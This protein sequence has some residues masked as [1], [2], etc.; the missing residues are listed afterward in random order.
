MKILVVNCGSSS[1]KCQLIEIEQE[2]CLA[3][4]S[5][6][7][8]GNNAKYS[9]EK[10]D[11]NKVK[12]ELK[13]I[14][15]EIAL[16]KIIDDLIQNNVINSIN[17]VDAIGH[18]IVHGGEFFKNSVIINDTV[19]LGIQNCCDLAPLHNPAHL[20]GINAC[21]KIFDK[22]M[23]A[24]FDT[25]FHQTM[26]KKAFIYP[27][28]YEYYEKYH[29]RKYGFHGTSH[30]Y[31]SKKAAEL[32]GKD[33]TKLKMITCH[34]GN[35]AS[36]SAIQNGKC[37]NTTMG[38]TPLAGIMM[39]T[40]SGDIDPSIIPFLMKKENLTISEIENILN[41]KSGLLG[42]SKV[43]SDCREIKRE[44]WENN[45]KQALFAL[46][47]FSYRIKEYL[48]AFISIM[49]GID[50]LV[51]TAGLGENFSEIR[52][53]ICEN[54]SFFGIEI[55]KEKNV[56]HGKERIISTD[57]SKVKIVVIPTNEEL[58]IARETKKTI[59]KTND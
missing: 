6:E 12:K 34:L 55:D 25:A 29:L 26:P 38:F 54:T 15:H 17:D 53:M 43:S 59:Q 28:P 27:V 20:I 51:F 10:K 24:V 57:S 23:V 42:L 16:N 56:L 18:R 5:I 1:L 21:K 36:L 2:V 58:M 47:K 48:G 22:K 44:A 41:T 35:G 50:V 32:I 31:V 33:I 11:S 52:E 3:K 19:I 8:I 7:E 37:V 13:I 40:R 4:A 14:N 30:E 39:G 45:N 46:E 9:F 49:N